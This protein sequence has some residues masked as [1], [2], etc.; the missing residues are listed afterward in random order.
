MASDPSSLRVALIT[1]GGLLV[2]LAV[3][4]VLIGSLTALTGTDAAGWL[5]VA[6]LIASVAGYLAVL[7]R[8]T[9]ASSVL[10]T[11]LS[12]T[13]GAVAAYLIAGGVLFGLGGGEPL[14][15]PAFALDQFSAPGIYLVAVLSA[16]AAIGFRMGTPPHRTDADRP[17]G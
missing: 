6:M 1:A 9:A 7:L 13:L 16:L 5:T 11:V 2:A 17:V 8:L 10:A 12:P 14:R 4:G 15:G 3:G